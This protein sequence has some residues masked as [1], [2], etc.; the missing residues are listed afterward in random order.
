MVMA[1]MDDYARE[2]RPLKNHLT[3]LRKRF[4]PEELNLHFGVPKDA[5]VWPGLWSEIEELAQKGLALINKHRDFFLTRR[6]PSAMYGDGMYWYDLFLFIHAISIAQAHSQNVHDE[7]S[8]ETVDSVLKCLI[9]ISEY[10]AVVPGDIFKRNWEA[11]AGFLFAF[12]GLAGT[13]VSMAEGFEEGHR[14]QIVMSAARR[15]AER[16]HDEV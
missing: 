10:T 15:A 13:A 1:D 12:P 4:N 9:E 8:A 14:K 5:E 6:D 2:F 3:A 7:P 11:L 16:E